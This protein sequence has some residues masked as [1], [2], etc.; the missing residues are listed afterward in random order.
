M[1]QN[2]SIMRDL[3]KTEK[4]SN[5]KRL[6]LSQH[7]HIARSF[8]TKQIMLFSYHFKTSHYIIH[9]I[10]EY[11]MTEGG[12]INF[13]MYPIAINYLYYIYSWEKSIFVEG[14][15]TKLCSIYI[16]IFWPCHKFKRNRSRQ[17]WANICQWFDF[18]SQ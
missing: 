13:N 11:F 14:E 2:M 5:S 10:F 9:K 4:L 18:S 16:W 7:G 15:T 3:T 6:M 17:Y 12:H 1:L 8:I